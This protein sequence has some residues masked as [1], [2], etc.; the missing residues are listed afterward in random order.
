MTAPKLSRDANGEL[1][2]ERFPL[3]RRVEHIIAI[4]AFTVLVLTGFPQKFF[5]TEWAHALLALFGGL[6]S[7]RTIHRVAGF[8]FSA[9]LI[10]HIA[11]IVV[12]A[13]LKRM[14]MTMLPVP[15]DLRDA[16]ENLR[17]YF[18]LRTVPPKLPKFDYRQKFEYIGMVMGSL[19]MVA[20]G[21]LL[22]WPVQATT[23][24]GGEWI[25]A[26]R[27]AHSNEAVL[28]LL[29][30]VVWHIYSAIFSPEV[31]P[32]DKSMFTGGMPLEELK[33][34][35]GR[36]YDYLFPKGHPEIDGPA[37]PKSTNVVEMNRKAS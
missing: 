16:W 1:H 7:S 31:F 30:L 32:L 2:I 8:V 9:Q 4:A 36:E 35:H 20:S 21:V 26:S 10:V 11:V 33:H 22:I 25:A 37:E 14:R 24:L 23:W 17:F 28:A 13:A 3:W 15:Q 12:G 6:E 27:V 34:R 19:I 29:V 18:G 5:D